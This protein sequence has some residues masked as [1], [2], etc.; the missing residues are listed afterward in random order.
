MIA[1]IEQLDQQ[2]V[3]AINGLHQPWLDEIMWW[4]SARVTWIPLYIYLFYILY[5][6]KGLQFSLLFY[7][8]TVICIIVADFISV[9]ALKEVVQRYRPS[10]HLILSEQL[11]YYIQ[12]NGKPYI[13]GEYGFVS[14]HATNFFVIAGCL[15]FSFYKSIPKIVYLVY[16]IAL[17]V[18]FSRIYLG[19]HYPTDVLGGALLGT[20]VSF[21]FTKFLWNAKN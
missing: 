7:S 14:S 11:H 4:V 6:Q 13:G 15:A 9:Y 20:V 21:L 1:L 18:C 16:G 10:H 2:L 5:K 17:L 3:L 19:V 8:F 12:S